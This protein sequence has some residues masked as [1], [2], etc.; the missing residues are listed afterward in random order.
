M[1]NYV[2]SPGR[3]ISPRHPLLWFSLTYSPPELQVQ[4]GYRSGPD[5]PLG[6]YEFLQ[7]RPTARLCSHSGLNALELSSLFTAISASGTALYSSSSLHGHIC[8]PLPDDTTT[9]PL[10]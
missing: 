4:V 8:T 3:I 2:A 6:S 10:L 9:P 7:A 5:S 1:T